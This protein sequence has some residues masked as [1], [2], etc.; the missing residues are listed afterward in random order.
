[1]F[2]GHYM[3]HPDECFICTLNVLLGIVFCRCQVKL[4]DCLIQVFYILLFC[5]LILPV[6]ERRIQKI[7]TLNI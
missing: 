5:L 2:V 4:V 7:A 3:A 1:M 6:V